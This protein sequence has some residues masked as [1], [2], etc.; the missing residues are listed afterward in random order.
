MVLHFRKMI[1]AMVKYYRPVVIQVGCCEAVTRPAKDFLQLSINYMCHYLPDSFF[2]S[3]IVSKM[4]KAIDDI[5][6]GKETYYCFLSPEEFRNLYVL[7]CRA[8]MGR[9]GIL[10]GLVRPKIEDQRKIDQLGEYN[11]I[12][13]EVAEYTDN[14]FIDVWN[15]TDAYSGDTTHI[16]FEGHKIIFEKIQEKINE[17]FG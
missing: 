2:D 7:G 14:Y 4:E 10:M 5:C 15:L 12:I 9:Q 16:T 13:K 3:I 8:L 6:K 1:K 11:N 17:C